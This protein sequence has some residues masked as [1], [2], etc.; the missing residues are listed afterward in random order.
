MIERVTNNFRRVKAIAPA[1][2]MIISDEVY[3]LAVVEGGE[4]VGVMWFP[5]SA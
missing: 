3:Y 5:H 4:D 1:W 2:N